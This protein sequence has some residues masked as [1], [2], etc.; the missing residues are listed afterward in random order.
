MNG[1]SNDRRPSDL[2]PSKRSKLPA[3]AKSFVGVSRWRALE[4][5]QFRALTA[6]P[7]REV[8]NA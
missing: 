4:R 8:R 6:S 2:H 7:S 1:S 3:K 5:K